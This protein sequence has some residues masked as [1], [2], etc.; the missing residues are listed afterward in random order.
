MKLT[1]GAQNM[2]GLGVVAMGQW[3]IVTKPNLS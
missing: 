3:R 2:T 1:A